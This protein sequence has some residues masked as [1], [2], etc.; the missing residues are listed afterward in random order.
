M[1]EHLLHACQAS[2]LH[3]AQLSQSLEVSSGRANVRVTYLKDEGLPGSPFTGMGSHAV[4]HDAA[5]HMASTVRKQR[6]MITADQSLSPPFP[7]PHKKKGFLLGTRKYTQQG[8]QGEKL[9]A[10]H[11][12]PSGDC[13]MVSP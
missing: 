6:D 3:S 9:S 11:R 8:K 10:M 12:G 5:G 1:T 4:E 13:T 7:S 2:F